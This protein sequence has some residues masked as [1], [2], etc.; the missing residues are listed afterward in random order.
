[1]VIYQ[2]YVNLIFNSYLL[3]F[4]GTSDIPI[5]NNPVELYTS[6]RQKELKFCLYVEGSS[7]V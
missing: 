2:I 6:N 1:M 7:N 5:V 4:S 3:F